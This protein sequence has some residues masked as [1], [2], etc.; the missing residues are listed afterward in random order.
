MTKINNFSTMLLESVQK[1]GQ[2]TLFVGEG[3]TKTYKDFYED[4]Q[5]LSSYFMGNN[6]IGKKIGIY[7]SNS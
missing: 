3:F 7:A 5:R 1:Y 6:L 4:V 2:K